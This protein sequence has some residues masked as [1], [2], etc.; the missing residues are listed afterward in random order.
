V[1]V[2]RWDPLR[3][4]LELRE[5]MNRLF[6]ETLSRSG[7]PDVGPGWRPP[8]DLFEEAERYLL[9]ADLPGLGSSEVE[10]QV[11]DGRLVLRGERRPEPGVAREA[12]LRIERPQG[13][14]AV[15]VALPPSV[16]RSRIQ[17][18]HRNGVLEVVL[19]KRKPGAPT[20]IDVSTG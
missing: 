11:E 6:E 5:R 15:E 19:P 3:D 13:P 12:Y 2:Q 18:T 7:S 10:I 20:R 17:A 14:F 16:E 4:L 8:L 1:A 9:R